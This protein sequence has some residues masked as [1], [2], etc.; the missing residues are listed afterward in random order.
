MLRG[1][2]TV[3]Q[4]GAEGSPRGWAMVS[5]IALSLNICERFFAEPAVMGPSDYAPLRCRAVRGDSACSVA[6]FF[7]SRHCG[8]WGTFSATAEGASSTASGFFKGRGPGRNQ[9]K[10]KTKKTTIGQVNAL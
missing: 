8:L 10:K 6:Q 2:R 7:C 5:E 4:V 9:K 1:E 3:A